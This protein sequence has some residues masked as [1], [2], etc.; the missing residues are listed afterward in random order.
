M[1]YSI[2]EIWTKYLN[3]IHFYFFRFLA[4]FVGSMN[5]WTLGETATGATTLR[6]CDRPHTL[7]NFK[8]RDPSVRG[9]YHFHR[10]G[11]LEGIARLWF[12]WAKGLIRIPHPYTVEQ[13]LQKSLSITYIRN[14]CPRSSRF[15]E[16]LCVVYF[17]FQ[18]L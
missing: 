7:E 9:V 13:T 16:Y 2:I 10:F 4:S 11:F 15:V 6:I 14:D 8:L 3:E 17:R 18:E 12:Q 1:H 5:Q